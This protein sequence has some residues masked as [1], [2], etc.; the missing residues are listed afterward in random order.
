[1]INTPT[2]PLTR[3]LTPILMVALATLG[4][5]ACISVLPKTAGPSPRY[6]IS[7]VTPRNVPTDPVAWSLVVAD[8]T[9]SQLFNTV[10]VPVMSAKNQF[11]FLAGSEWVDRVPVL[12]Q[13]AVVRTFE[14]TDLITNVGDLSSQ[15][16]SD[17]TLRT[18]IRSFHA[19]LTGVTPVVTIQVFARFVNDDGR[20]LASRNFSVREETA[21]D[22]VDDLMPAFN[23][24]AD[25]ILED[26]VAWSFA[27]GQ[28]AERAAG[29]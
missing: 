15:P 14:N 11:Q 1:M 6:A 7:S 8:P 22:S 26:L 24:A 9:S 27:Q 28:S 4:L 13:R 23:V 5:S 21:S 16:I 12:L 10:K 20:V 29:T 18:D 25:R 2:K 3:K 19:D 17:Y